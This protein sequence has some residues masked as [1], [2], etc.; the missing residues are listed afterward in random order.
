M[1]RWYERTNKI[2]L[3]RRSIRIFDVHTGYWIICFKLAERILCYH[4]DPSKYTFV[5]KV[6][7][8]LECGVE[9][10]GYC[11]RSDKSKNIVVESIACREIYT[12]RTKRYKD[13][14]HMYRYIMMLK[15]ILVNK[16]LFMIERCFGKVKCIDDPRARGV[17]ITSYIRREQY[18]G[19]NRCDEKYR[20][21]DIESCACMQHYSKIKSPLSYLLKKDI[22]E[23]EIK[24]YVSDVEIAD[25]DEDIECVGRECIE[26]E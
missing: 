26:E 15:E 24:E 6:D 4:W 12:W 8:M 5:G 18:L 25:I 14:H 1:V 17:F 23:S 19:Y 9:I 7:R 16:A 11:R 2:Y 3:G 13:I 21:C 22:R 10:C 20:Y